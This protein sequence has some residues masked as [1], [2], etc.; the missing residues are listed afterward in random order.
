MNRQ[1][2]QKSLG[3]SHEYECRINGD[4]YTVRYNYFH[5]LGYSVMRNGTRILV[6]DRIKQ[7]YEYLHRV[8]ATGD[9][10]SPFQGR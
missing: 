1:L 2:L 10:L 6:L 3:Y 8:E 4:T 5:L 9:Y 7:V